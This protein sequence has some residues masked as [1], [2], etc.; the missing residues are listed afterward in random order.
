MKTHKGVNASFQRLTVGDNRIDRD[1]RGFLNRGYDLKVSAD[2]S[3]GPDA[4]VSDS[5]A[6]EAIATAQR[7]VIG[8]EAA[9]VAPDAGSAPPG[10]GSVA[11]A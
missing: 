5:A 7:F 2:Y 10:T 1:L 3:T 6:R 8:C 9:I 4:V 11:G